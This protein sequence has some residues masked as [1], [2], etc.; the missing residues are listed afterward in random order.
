[1]KQDNLT[2]KQ[3]IEQSHLFCRDG[4][5]YQIMHCDDE[6]FTAFDDSNG[7]ELFIYYDEV[8]LDDD[9][10]YKCMNP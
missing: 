7:N 2:V 9:L 5:V 4:D 6:H 3:I 1:M 8:D 10:I